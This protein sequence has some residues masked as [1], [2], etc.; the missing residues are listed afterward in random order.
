MES[1]STPAAVYISSEQ[2]HQQQLDGC[3]VI[4][5][6]AAAAVPF[7]QAAADLGYADVL[8]AAPAILQPPGKKQRQQQQQQEVLALLPAHQVLLSGCGYFEA[9]FSQRWHRS[10]WQ[11]PLQ[12]SSS[13]ADAAAG[14]TTAAGG[15]S[16]SSGVQQLPRLPVVLVPEAD[17]HV[18]A[19]LQHWL[20]T[21]ELQISLPLHAA[22]SYSGACCHLK[23]QQQHQHQQEQQQ[24][25]V[26]MLQPQQQPAVIAQLNGCVQQ[27]QQQQQ[28]MGVL[29]LNGCSP[30]CHACR[31]L[32]RLWRCADLLLLPALQQQCLAALEAAVS[33]LLPCGCCV[34]LLQDCCQLGVAPAADGIVAGLLTR[35]GK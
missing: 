28:E 4:L 31:T 14:V 1:D 25:E 2:Q 30:A 22:A 8:L 20:Y 29:Q 19:A 17:I 12:D 16:S 27:Q 34:V 18:A 26:S 33:Q 13:S 9:L 24:Q 35:F 10:G 7:A 3:D 6:G 5:A 11:E 32:L 21:G 15:S 23:H